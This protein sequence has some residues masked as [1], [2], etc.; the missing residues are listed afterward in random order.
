MMK[1]HGLEIEALIRFKEKGESDP[2]GLVVVLEQN[3]TR[4]PTRRQTMFGRTTKPGAQSNG[5]ADG[6]DMSTSC[7]TVSE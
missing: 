2:L 6:M 5:I 1:E 7:G 4:A 3:G